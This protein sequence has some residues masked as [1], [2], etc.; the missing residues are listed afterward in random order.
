MAR[1]SFD[2]NINLK[3]FET[4][5][6]RLNKTKEGMDRMRTSTSGLRRQVGALRN[7]MLLVSFAIGGVAVVINRFVQAASGFEDVKTRLVGLTGGV[8]KAN[9]AFKRFNAVAATTPFQLQDVVNAGAQLEAFGVNSKATLSAVTDLA[10]FMGTTATE[11]ANALGRA[12]AGGVGAADILRDKGIRQIIQDSQG[13]ED[14]T[15]LTLPQFRVALIASL[16]DPDGRIAGSAERMSE[17]FSGS[18]SNMRDALTRVS[19]SVGEMLIPHLLEATKAVEDFARGFNKKRMAE[20]ATSLTIV[21][22]IYGLVQV[23]AIAATIATVAFQKTLRRTIAGLALFFTASIMDQLLVGL[24]VFKDLNK[25][26]SDFEKELEKA[27]QEQKDYLRSLR[28]TTN[29]VREQNNAYEEL[30][31]SIEK[32]ETALAVRLAVML[33]ETELGK[34]RVTALLGENRMISEKEIRLLSQID[35]IKANQKAE[36]DAL[37]TKKETLRVEKEIRKET[38]DSRNAIASANATA[39]QIQKQLDGAEELHIE[40][41]EI[42]NQGAKD[43]AKVLGGPDGLQLQYTDLKEAIGESTEALSLDS[44]GVSLSEGL[45]KDHVQALIELINIRLEEA[46]SNVKITD[47]K[48]QANEEMLNMLDQTTSLWSQNM[49]SRQ[50]AEISQLKNTGEYRN[51]SAE[52]RASMEKDALSKFKTEANARFR[53]EQ[54]MSLGNI[55]MKTS[56]AVAKSI[57]LLPLTLGSPLKEINYA[58]GIAQAGLVASQQPPAFALGG[59]FVTQGPQAIM[60]GDNPGG[61][62]RVQVTP[63]SSPNVN[64]PQGGGITVNISAPLVDDTVVQSIIPAIER[65]RRMNLA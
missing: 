54:A 58:L 49:K 1:N 6:K 62:E 19:A 44:L 57:A 11:A 29:E 40:K 63:L 65:A 25:A 52:Q 5:H 36:E 18:V 33:E 46:E 20:F 2:I 35:A 45:V 37:K 59:D 7:N 61:R 8:D 3:G 47:N 27:K 64:G 50:D 41:M 56:E 53:I 28:E 23:R 21:A 15:K 10:A 38:L 22:G 42:L 34:A 12:F 4:A 43:L 32:S 31:E 14:I 17:T 51:A 13:I 39:M 30:K 55:Y 48:K 16:T 60:V 26:V 24:G 9:E